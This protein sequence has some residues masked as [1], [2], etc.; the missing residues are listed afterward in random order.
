MGG[1][2]QG[3]R[4]GCNVRIVSAS[5]CDDGE[6]MEG[7]G[8]QAAVATATAVATAVEAMAAAM[9]GSDGWSGGRCGCTSNVVP[10]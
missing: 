5:G 4:G 9:G 2:G 7:P 3:R 6:G 8:G 1:G 10:S